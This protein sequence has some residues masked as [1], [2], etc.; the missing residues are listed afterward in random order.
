MPC[1]FMIG[2]TV[3]QV[4]VKMIICKF[5]LVVMIIEH[6]NDSEDQ[7]AHFGVR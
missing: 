1:L 7:L 2:F 6:I 3:F 4:E 5:N